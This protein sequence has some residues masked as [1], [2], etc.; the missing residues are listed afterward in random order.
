MRCKLGGERRSAAI[1]RW[2][3]VCWS[4]VLVGCVV[5]TMNCEMTAFHVG[6]RQCGGCKQTLAL[7]D[8]IAK[9]QVCCSVLVNKVTRPTCVMML[10]NSSNAVS[11]EDEMRRNDFPS[12]DMLQIK[13][14]KEVPIVFAPNLINLSVITMFISVCLWDRTETPFYL[15][16]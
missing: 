3:G 5:L 12:A 1:D 9:P 6:E 14:Q 8:V 4:I 16:T 2:G 11:G 15:P 10:V 13:N 7:N